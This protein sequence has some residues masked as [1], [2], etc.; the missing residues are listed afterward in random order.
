MPSYQASLS[1]CTRSLTP[2]LIAV[3]SRKPIVPK[4]VSNK[5]T[6]TREAAE[7]LGKD[8][9]RSD[10][11]RMISGTSILCTHVP[12]RTVGNFRWMM[13]ALKKMTTHTIPQFLEHEKHKNDY[14]NERKISLK[15]PSLSYT[16][17]LVQGSISRYAR[18]CGKM[19]RRHLFWYGLT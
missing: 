6:E 16:M 1:P 11:Y 18:N 17:L 15:I 19:Y 13:F 9:G 4:L 8:R 14:E 7:E 5:R 3:T 12:F 10:M 2:R